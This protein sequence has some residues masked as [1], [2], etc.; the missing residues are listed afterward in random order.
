MSYDIRTRLD[1]IGLE[2]IEVGD[3][4]PD[5]SEWVIA[6]MSH[7]TIRLE[8]EHDGYVQRVWINQR[9]PADGDLPFNATVVPDDG[10]ERQLDEDDWLP[11]VLATAEAYM[12]GYQD[13]NQH[14]N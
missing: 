4:Y 13:R 6:E 2:D 14:E 12:T 11:Y 8:H 10:E 3:P 9:K 7:E 5:A 1:L